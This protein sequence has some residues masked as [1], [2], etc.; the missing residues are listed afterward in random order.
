[1]KKLRP[2]GR[3]IAPTIHK[4]IGKLQVSTSS[5]DAPDANDE[6]NG[7]GL[8][9]HDCIETQEEKRT[10]GN[11]DNA[12]HSAPTG[13]LLGPSGERSCSNGVIRPGECPAEDGSKSQAHDSPDFAPPR[14]AH[15]FQI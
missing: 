14:L 12:I 8:A 13:G 2:E 3:T 4:S 6:G 9:H 11:H 5:P 7:R 10:R 15:G 1:M